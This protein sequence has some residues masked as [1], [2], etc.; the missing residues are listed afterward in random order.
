[1][2][3][4]RI[5]AALAAAALGLGLSLAAVAPAQ[6]HDSLLT[7]DPAPDAVLTTAP[8]LIEFT[9][10]GELMEPGRLV[11]V[12]DAQGTDWVDG[13]PT[14]EG[15][16]LFQS[17]KPGMPDGSYQVRWQVVSSDGHPISGWF[18]FAVGEPTPGGIPAPGAEGG[19]DHAEDGHDLAV[20]GHDHAEDGHDPA[21]H[22]HA[23]AGGNPFG[24]GLT[25][26]IGAAL[27]AAVVVIIVLVRRKKA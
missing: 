9:F 3:K 8:E 19:H 4:S 5:P 13:A 12:I 7:S 26:T 1:M 20:D 18:D 23:D 2:K 24:L 6:A 16:Q 25:V 10:S 17:L 15:T 27:A 22:E 11:V 21:E 14:A